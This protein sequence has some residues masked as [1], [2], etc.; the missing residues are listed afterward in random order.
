MCICTISRLIMEPIRQIIINR[1]NQIYTKSSG[2]E[3][4]FDEYDD[5]SLVQ[6]FEKLLKGLY[7]Q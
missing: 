1:I 4:I 3:I 5:K 2:K 7:Q 6:L